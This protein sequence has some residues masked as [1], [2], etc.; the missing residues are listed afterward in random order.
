MYW[1]S[2]WIWLQIIFTRI[3]VLGHRIGFCRGSCDSGYRT[4]YVS[5]LGL[6]LVTDH[7]YYDYYIRTPDWISVLVIM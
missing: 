1:D 7:Y 2:D 4:I 6:D 5:G 3:T